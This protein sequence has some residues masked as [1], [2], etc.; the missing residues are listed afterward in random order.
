MASSTTRVKTALYVDFDNIYLGLRED[1][2]AAAEQ[3]AT[4]P[5]RWLRWMEEGMGMQGAERAVLVRRCYLN[6]DAFSR[7]RAYFTRS[8]FSVVDCPSLT[9]RGKSSSDI[10]MVMDMLDALQHETR[11]D[12][13]VIMSA[14]AD[15]TPVLQRLRMHDRR[16]AVLVS[17]MAAPA[18]RAGCDLLISEDTFIESALGIV[19]D[20]PAAS[21]APARAPAPPSASRAELLDAIAL[22]VYEETSA[23][24]TL[25]ATDLP[26][27]YREFREF[28]PTSSWLG[29]FSLRGLT[30][31]VVAR[32]PELRILEGETTWRVGVG[33][34][35]EAQDA[36][37]AR[38]S[39]DGN[40][41]EELRRRIVARVGELV[42]QSPEPVGM[43]RAAHQIIHDFG[44]ELLETHWLGAGTFK[45]LLAG[46]GDLPFA[47]FTGSGGL[48]Y[49]PERHPQP[50]ERAPSDPLAGLPE[51][52]ATFIAR[53]N[54]LTETPRLGPA[55][56]R[57]LFE[58][59]AKELGRAPYS[60][61]GTGKA[62]R[63]QCVERGESI[64]RQSVTF[65]LRGL[66]YVGYPLYRTDRGHSPEELGRAF[67]GNLVNLLR[68]AQAE[69]TDADLEMLDAWLGAAPAADSA[70]ADPPPSAGP[71]SVAVPSAEPS[72]LDPS[73]EASAAA[74]PSVPEDG[75]RELAAAST[76]G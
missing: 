16:T 63:D 29:F 68:Q 12:E 60:L 23:N 24:G 19:A 9:K 69:V 49:D 38:P 39:A 43:A 1:S 51:P 58:V 2:P 66:A 67:R 55:Q 18:Y 28:T 5:D 41:R 4:A 14:D 6:P 64:A 32:R 50:E 37:A 56:Y 21:A 15:F 62:V 59:I 42:A 8:G 45:H 17:G 26:R 36:P 53:V 33:V 61:M 25:P 40:G 10:V 30:E 72:S 74:V 54:R 65:V 34:A 44:A 20:E 52:L 73:P 47:I 48:L 11:F 75:D 3:F 70:P 35:E 71:A 76:G 57:L 27:I 22:R 31:A 46:A 7:Y 13:F